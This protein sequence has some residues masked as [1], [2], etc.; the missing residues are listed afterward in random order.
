MRLAAWIL[1]AA[2]AIWAAE[3][4]NALSLKPLP[5]GAE[6][7]GFTVMASGPGKPGTARVISLKEG[8]KAIEVTGGN[9]NGGHFT[10]VRLDRPIPKDGQASLKFRIVGGKGIQAA[11]VFF[12]MQPNASDYYLLAIKDQDLFLTFF[13]DHRAVK[14]VKNPDFP[15]PKDGSWHTLEFAYK[16]NRFDWKLNGREE[17]FAYHE[18]LDPDYKSG[19]FGFWVRSDTKV[20]FKDMNLLAPPALAQVAKHKKLIERLLLKHNRLRSLQLLA[21]P[22][23]GKPPVIMGSFDPSEV[24]QPGHKI[25]GEAIEN[26]ET[27]YGLEGKISTVTVPLYGNDDKVILG[28]ARMKF[29]AQ[30]KMVN[31]KQLD[32]VLAD[33]IAKEVTAQIPNRKALL[34][35]P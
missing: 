16:G 19:K 23:A 11:G 4:E 30:G 22:A 35:N 12:R 18:L 7:R 33:K 20:Q 9:P 6:P 21:R 25:A 26:S 3:L 13:D 14:G 8:V 28:A 34:I 15:A 32:I 2:P 17:F 31:R 27:Y 24:G 5:I 29:V 10:L 1:L